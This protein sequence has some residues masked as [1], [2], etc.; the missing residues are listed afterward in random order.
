[1]DMSSFLRDKVAKRGDEADHPLPSNA[2]IKNVW[3]YKCTPPVY[4]HGVE[5]S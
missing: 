4:L 3:L 5:L 1:M 2:K